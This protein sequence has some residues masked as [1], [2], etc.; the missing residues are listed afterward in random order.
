MRQANDPKG[1]QQRRQS[2]PKPLPQRR[3]LGHLLEHTEIII[4][5]GFYWCGPGYEW[6]RWCASRMALQ[7]IRLVA[8]PA[9]CRNC[10]DCGNPGSVSRRLPDGLGFRCVGPRLWR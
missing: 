2:D 4:Q 5:V 9:D 8:A 3:D 10:V 6:K 7:S 1:D